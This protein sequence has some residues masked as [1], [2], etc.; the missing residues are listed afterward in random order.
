LQHYPLL[1][2]DRVDSLDMQLRQRL[3][4]RNVTVPT[5]IETT[6]A[7]AICAFA[8]QGIGLGIVNPYIA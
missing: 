5:N 8:V 4:Q 1:C 6:Y 3:V 2:L 7:A